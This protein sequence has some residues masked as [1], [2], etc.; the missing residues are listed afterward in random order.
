MATEETS[1]KGVSS[2]GCTTGSGAS[3]ATISPFT[4]LTLSLAETLTCRPKMGPTQHKDMALNLSLWINVLILVTK[5]F[6]FIVS[7]SLSV[8]A[9]LVDSALDILSQIILYW[10]E[11]KR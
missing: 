5:I 3:S 11:G 4:S 1:L 8:L 2:L 6:A 9:A 10:A 7:G